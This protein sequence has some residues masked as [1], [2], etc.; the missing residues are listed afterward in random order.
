MM[1]HIPS[2]ACASHCHGPRA[3]LISAP[4]EPVFASE[5]RQRASRSVPCL[6]SR[7]VDSGHELMT[8]TSDDC[9]TC[10]HSFSRTVVSDPSVTWGNGSFRTCF[11]TSTG[12]RNVVISE[13]LPFLNEERRWMGI[14]RKHE[15]RLMDGNGEKACH[16]SFPVMVQ[17]RSIPI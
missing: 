5:R 15:E 14:V 10:Q 11:F 9:E 7:R 8:T 6:A 12:G 2:V 4:N 1:P 3:A 17:L 13:F 16:L